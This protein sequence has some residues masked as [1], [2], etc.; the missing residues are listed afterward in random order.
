MR[1]INFAAEVVD[2]WVCKLPKG[3]YVEGDAD[4]PQHKKLESI[5]HLTT[6]RPSDL[7]R[8]PIQ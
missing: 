3:N 4:T 6:F 2:R 1:A 5:Q 7:P 8:G